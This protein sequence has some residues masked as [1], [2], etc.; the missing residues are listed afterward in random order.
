MGKVSTESLGPGTSGNSYGGPHFGV[1]GRFS[2]EGQSA[3][4]LPCPSFPC[5]FGI[6]C[7]FP[8]R[9]IP[10]FFERFSLLFQGF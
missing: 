6:P 7:L 5:F 8:L 9:G 10:C 1:L 2:K 4:N 3:I